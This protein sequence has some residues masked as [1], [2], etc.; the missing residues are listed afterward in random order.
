MSRPEAK[1]TPTAG[2]ATGFD[3]RN[4]LSGESRIRSPQDLG[5]MLQSRSLAAW[6]SDGHERT[7]RKDIKNDQTR[8]TYGRLRAV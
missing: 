2:S 5:A 8:I 6:P 3:Q 4:M 1:W 7:A